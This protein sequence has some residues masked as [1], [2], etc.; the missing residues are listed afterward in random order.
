[1]SDG[2]KLLGAI[3]DTGSVHTI[4]DLS[5]ELFIEEEVELYNF[6]RQHYRRY[7]QIPA[8]ATVEEDLGIEVPEAPETIDYYI[9]RVHDRRLYSQVRDKFNNLKDALREFDMDEA[10]DIIDEMRQATRI[11]HSESDIRSLREAAQ[12]VMR[13][14]AFSHDN[15][16]VSGIPT[17]WTKFDHR[18]GGYQ[19]GDLVSWV[20]RPSMG[21]C[22]AP[23]TPVLLYSG[24]VVRI[25]SLVAGDRLMGPDSKPRTVLSTNTGEEEMFEVRPSRGESWRC[26]RSHI[27]ALICGKSLDTKHTKGSLHYYSVAEYLAL[28]SRVQKGMRLWRTGVDFPEAPVPLDPYFIGLWLGGG[29]VGYARISTTDHEIVSYLENLADSEGLSLVQYEKREGFCPQYGISGKKGSANFVAEYVQRKCYNDIGKRIPEVYK[30]NSRTVRLG[31]LAGLIDSDGYRYGVGYEIATE[32]Y[33]LSD[34][35]LYLARSCGFGATRK[36]K[37]VNGVEYYRITIYGKGLSEVPCLL[38]RKRIVVETAKEGVN[39]A[40]TLTSLGEGKYFGITLD[41]DHLYLLGD[42]TVTHNTYIMLR[43]A[44]AAWQ[45]GYSVLVVTMEMTIEQITRRLAAMQAGINP[46]YIRK[47]TLSSYALRRLKN[48][49]DTMAGAERFRM[50]SGGLRKKVSDVEILVQEYRPDIV[51]ID[52]V[53]MMQSESKRANSKVEKV[54][55]V[56]DDLKKLTLSQNIPVVVT[57]QFNRA[58]GKKGK[59]GSLENIAYSDAISTHSSLVISL[60]EGEAPNQKTRRVAQ[61]LKGREGEEGKFGLN[62]TFAPIN[63]EETTDEESIDG[64]GVATSTAPVAAGV[65]WMAG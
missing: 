8:I 59:D 3:I 39:S 16:G 18:V 33:G 24:K 30:V 51:F 25:D 50:F 54:S 1:M 49:I 63:F 22:M 10:K 6:I 57:T 62:Y 11:A 28:P 5:V 56:Y 17:G 58:A 14:Y 31:V 46:D 19:P 37:Y 48:Y 43:Q 61:F 52:G 27:L 35:I 38:P 41:K 53:Y 20:A 47:G 4:R 40:F 44:S 9:K 55:E 21:K 36:L 23:E 34:D 7:G 60:S 2:L 42:F 26:N 65:D 13:E 32:Y 45:F 12:D 64:E 29:T 15:P